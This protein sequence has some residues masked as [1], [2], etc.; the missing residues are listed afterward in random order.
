MCV[1]GLCVDFGVE[2]V[3]CRDVVCGGC[4]DEL[5]QAM[6]R[7]CGRPFRRCEDVDIEVSDEHFRFGEIKK[8]VGPYNNVE[9]CEN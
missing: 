6:C 9:K 5:V 2:F 7:S 8:S 4:G 1:N 3:Q